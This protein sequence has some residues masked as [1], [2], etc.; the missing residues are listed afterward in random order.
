M[1]TISTLLIYLARRLRRPAEL[2]IRSCF[3]LSSVTLLSL[4]AVVPLSAQAAELIIRNHTAN[5]YQQVANIAVE[6]SE[7]VTEK[8]VVHVSTAAN[9]ATPGRDFYGVYEV[10]E[11]EP[12][13]VKKVVRIP[14]LN[15]T[16]MEEK[17]N[18][19]ATIW[20]AEGATITKA[21]S[22][23]VIN[24]DDSD[25]IEIPVINLTSIEV[26]EN[27]GTVTVPLVLSNPAPRAVSFVFATSGDTA[28]PGSD[29]YGMSEK[30]RF[31]S[32]EIAKSVTIKLVDDDVT[33]SNERINLN[34]YNVVG[35]AIGEAAGTITLL[36]DDGDNPV[37]G[38]AVKAHV[39]NRLGYGASAA[40]LAQINRL[41][42][43]G[44]IEAQ[45]SSDLAAPICDKCNEAAMTAAKLT[46]SLQSQSQ[47]AEVLVDFWFN[48]FNVDTVNSIVRNNLG[49][50]EGNYIRQNVFGQF[51]DMLVAVAKS[52]AML[53]Y[54]DNRSSTKEGLVI[55]GR[56]RG[57]NENYAR[58]LM[59][60]HTLGVNGGYSEEDVI[61]VARVLTGWRIKRVDTGE[62]PYVFEFR[63]RYHDTE[64]K[65]F[66]NGTLVIAADEGIVEGEK[67]LRILARHPKTASFVSRK[68]I[69]V[70]SQKH[71]LKR[72]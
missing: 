27:S 36:D 47:L 6:L 58:E 44:Y 2:T 51:E 62:E 35:A 10:I 24:D 18:F 1:R 37:N 34:L 46:R 38:L 13:Q 8:V 26:A 22:W 54:L 69:S 63:V 52:P 53:T 20:G 3:S 41:G 7:P 33:E 15:D 59:E 21:V 45:L 60:L 67:L 23:I 4:A 19:T 25:G 50:Y 9:T 49:R 48:H 70:S 31:A 11:F 17:E 68:L 71:R 30:V 42:V 39:L 66:M 43:D 55:G 57:L 65:N 40:S 5:E 72:W 29:F 32:G 16:E 14:I 64:P 61:T 28:T 56:E 12:G